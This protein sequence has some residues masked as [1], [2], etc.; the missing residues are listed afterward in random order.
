MST[1]KV[2]NIE[3]PSTTSG[4]IDIDTSGHVTVDGVAMPS[5]GALSNRNLIVNGAMAVA[6]RGTSVTGIT[7]SNTY[8]TVDR[9]RMAMETVSYTH[10]TLPTNREV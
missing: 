4:G 10:L 7:N 6:Q 8:R 9:W 5:A 2:T 1:L 3:N